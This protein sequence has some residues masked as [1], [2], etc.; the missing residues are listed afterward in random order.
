MVRTAPRKRVRYTGPSPATILAVL[1]RDGYAC[2]CCGVSV[3]GRVFDIQHRK[4]RSQGGSN[5]FTNLITA[6]RGHHNRW[7]SRRKSSD[8]KAG[9]TVRSTWDPARVRVLYVTA[10]GSQEWMWLLPDGTRATE[11][12]DWGL[13]A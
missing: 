4:R 11:K 5:C 6:L 9:Y 10:Y 7:D 2:V 1:I 13:A 8:E 3:I 12:P